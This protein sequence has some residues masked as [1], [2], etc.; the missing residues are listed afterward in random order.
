MKMLQTIELGQIESQFLIAFSD[1]S[2]WFRFANQQEIVFADFKLS[3]TSKLD[4][5][6]RA[7]LNS[8]QLRAHLLIKKGK[9]KKVVVDAMVRF[10][11]NRNGLH[12]KEEFLEN[13]I[14]LIV[15]NVG[16]DFKLT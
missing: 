8:L 11:Q 16:I 3:S 4:T 5:I 12:H 2:Q 6:E 9:N 14:P 7:K 10:L 1:Y 13:V 15:T